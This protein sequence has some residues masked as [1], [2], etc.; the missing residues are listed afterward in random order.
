[1]YGKHQQRR[2]AISHL[3]ELTTLKPPMIT[4]LRGV[5]TIYL[6]L[7][8]AIEAFED[9]NF[10]SAIEKSDLVRRSFAKLKGLHVLSLETVWI[11]IDEEELDYEYDEDDGY[12]YSTFLTDTQKA[13]LSEEF[14]A[15]LFGS[16]EIVS[17]PPE[18]RSSHRMRLRGK[19]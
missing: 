7:T 9:L 16:N 1:M 15:H 17:S 6:N 13:R 8:K 3:W 5:K 12:T 19:E 2:D 11:A 4:A 18:N 14:R 10:P